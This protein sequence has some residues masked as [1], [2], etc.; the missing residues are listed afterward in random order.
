MRKD[1]IEIQKR[2]REEDKQR[3]KLLEEQKKQADDLD[4]G[5]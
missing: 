4:R 3:V 1:E 2:I 5:Y